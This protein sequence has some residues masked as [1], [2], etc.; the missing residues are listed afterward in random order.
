[1]FNQTFSPFK[2]PPGEYK[3]KAFF[4]RFKQAIFLKKSIVN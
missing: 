3:A 1:M 4:F 2:P